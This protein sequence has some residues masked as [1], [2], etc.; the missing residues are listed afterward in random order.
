MLNECLNQQIFIG[1][2]NQRSKKAIVIHSGGMDSSLCLAIAIREFGVN[3]VLSL[4]FR[5]QQRHSHELTQAAKIS[6][7]WGVDHAELDINCLAAITNNA[8]INP[9]LD[10]IHLPN[11]APNTL[12]IGRNGLMAHIAGIHAE[13]LGAHCLYMGVIEVDGSHSNY[14]DCNR[15]YINLAE[16]KLRLDLDNP[17]FEIRTPLIK[18]SKK[19]TL[20]LANELGILE[21]LLLETITCYQ[22]LPQVGCQ[23]CP[24]CQL[25]NRGIHEFLAENPHFVMPYKI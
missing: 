12:V 14:R 10:I 16:E 7:E 3:Q 8:L 4:S 13:N 6:Q 9:N 15:N 25:R 23:T 17:N 11:Q 18:M 2:M 19:Q 1:Y 5:Y 20:E 24:A 22:G 21:Y